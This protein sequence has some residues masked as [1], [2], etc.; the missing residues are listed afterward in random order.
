MKNILPIGSGLFKNLI[1][2]EIKNPA[3]A[4]VELLAWLIDFTPRPLGY[5]Q[6]ILKDTNEIINPYNLITDSVEEIPEQGLPKDNDT[7][8]EKEFANT[9]TVVKEDFWQDGKDKISVTDNTDSSNL[10]IKKP[11]NNLKNSK[12]KNATIALIITL[13]LGGMYAIWQHEKSGGLAF[14]NVNTG[15]MYWAAD[16]YEKVPCTEKGKGFILPLDEERIK[17]FKRIVQEDTISEKSI[18]VIYYLKT[19]NKPEYFTSGGNHP[20][21]INRNLKILSRYIYDEYLRKREAPII[22]SLNERNTTDANKR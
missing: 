11:G 20:V 16:H 15:C 18:G 9:N 2:G 22:D 6:Q 12:L 5:A 4:N 7:E 3:S 10:T 13:F 14:G 1:R 17:N 21:Y 8:V 19:N